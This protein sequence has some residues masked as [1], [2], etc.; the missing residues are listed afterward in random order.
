M[1]LTKL[2]IRSL[3]GGFDSFSHRDHLLRHTTSRLQ[4]KLP[5]K[6]EN[7]SPEK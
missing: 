1:I 7:Q 5:K 4:L 3:H 2:L 6:Q